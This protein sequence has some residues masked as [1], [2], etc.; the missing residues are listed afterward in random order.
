MKALKHFSNVDKAELLHGLFPDEISALLEFT[1]GMCATVS[2]DQHLGRQH[3]QNPIIGFDDWLR[4]A[5]RVEGNIDHY[6]TT[7]HEN[8]KL[9]GQALFRGNLNLFTAYCLLNYTTIRQHP[10]PKFIKAADLLF[11]P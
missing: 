1:K 3:W 2:E 6:G 7:L 8:G 4:L 10:N 5:A 11:N 9:F